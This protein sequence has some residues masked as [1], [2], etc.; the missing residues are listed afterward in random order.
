MRSSIAYFQDERAALFAP[1][2]EKLSSC[3][4]A[5]DI[6]NLEIDPSSLD[7]LEILHALPPL[8]SSASSLCLYIGH[9]QCMS[10]STATYY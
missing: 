8:F 7:L 3:W 2:L 10:A 6:E 9:S 5:Y 4:K 1:L